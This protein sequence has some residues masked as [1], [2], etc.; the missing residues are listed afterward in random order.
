MLVHNAVAVVGEV[1]VVKA[2]SVLVI[3]ELLIRAASRRP[4]RPNAFPTVV[5]VFR[6]KVRS[7]KTRGLAGKTGGVA[8]KVVTTPDATLRPV[9]GGVGL[10]A[11]ATLPKAALPVT[12][13]RTGGRGYSG[14]PE[15]ASVRSQ[16]LRKGSHMFGIRNQWMPPDVADV[17]PTGHAANA[18]R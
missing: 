3:S 9:M 11:A 2:V 8:G 4:S 5:P 13:I 7:V 15:I 10:G 17:A 1:V 18:L 6:V 16:L 14:V 12:R